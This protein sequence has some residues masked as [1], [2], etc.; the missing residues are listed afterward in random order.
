MRLGGW[1][2]ESGW[3]SVDEDVLFSVFV[4]ILRFCG[5]VLGVRRRWLRKTIPKFIAHCNVHALTEQQLTCYAT[6]G[7]K[8]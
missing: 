8:C 1:G 5:C 4:F 2:R 7:Y 3:G 6:A